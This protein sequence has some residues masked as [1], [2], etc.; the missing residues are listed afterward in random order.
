MT[1][2]AL[3]LSH[4]TAPVALREKLAI[5]EPELASALAKLLGDPM[6]DEAVILSTCN[7]TEFYVSAKDAPKGAD[8]LRGF[9]EAQLDQPGDPAAVAAASLP[10]LGSLREHFYLLQDKAVVEHLFTVVSSLDSQIL[11]EA[12]ILGQV[13]SAYT[14]AASAGA[15]GALLNKLFKQAIECGR[16]VRNATAIGAQSVS[17]STAAV[18]LAQRVYESIT[19]LKVL[20][21]GT[22]QMGRLAA[23]YLAEKGA[24]QIIIANR[25]LANAEALAEEMQ[26]SEANQSEWRA[27]G[28]DEVPACLSAVDVALSCTAAAGYVLDVATVRA[29]RRRHRGRPLLLV[30]IA[31]PRDIEPA[32]GEEPNV[33]LYDLDDL[34]VI[35]DEHLSEREGEAKKAE[36]LV[37]E[38]VDGFVSWLQEQEVTPTIKQLHDK[39]SATVDKER[40]R[41]A[42]ELA[43][44]RGAPLSADELAVLEAMAQSITNKVLHGPTMRLRTQASDPDSYRYTEA[45]RYLFGLDTN[46]TG[47]PHVHHRK[48]QE[49]Q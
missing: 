18:N 36:I 21:I 41:A 22:G 6:I 20:L 27:V 16:L 29:G 5:E 32:A 35:V 33:Y 7:R 11:G 24:A 4:K 26:A 28:L 14:A 40:A 37:T 30:D 42:K 39:V 44:K 3:G 2:L 12:Q 38:Q 1:L 45:A 10:P 8:A 15:T 31:M 48:Q 46:P 13:R 17:I 34:G 25:T 47:I 49:S 43:K 9:L 19:G 23:Q